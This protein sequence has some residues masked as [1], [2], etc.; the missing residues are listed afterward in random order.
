MHDDR[1]M[2]PL[3]PAPKKRAPAPV[4]ERRKSADRRTADDRRE[5]P[6]RPEGRRR[7]GGRRATD[8]REA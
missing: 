6:P 1:S 8:P 2:R 7:G 4:T 5:L 3:K